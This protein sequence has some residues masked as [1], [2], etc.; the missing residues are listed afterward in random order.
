MPSFHQLQCMR[1]FVA[2]AEAGSFARAAHALQIGAASV[3]EHVANLER[4]LGAALFHRTTRSLHLTHEGTR[5]L[6]LCH[7]ILPR[8]DE[9]D[10]ELARPGGD[11]AL[12]GLLRIEMSDG[13]D[14][15]LLDAVH[16]FQRLHPAVSIHLYRSQ[17]PFDLAEA[18][19]DI[20]IRAVPPQGR[21]PART[22]GHSRTIF[23]AAPAYL[24]RMGVPQHPQDLLAHRCIGY[25]DPA[26]GRLWEWYFAEG[27]RRSFALDVPC[28]L[29]FS[30]GALRRR[31]AM[32][33]QGIINDIAHFVAE[34]VQQGMLVPIL[35]DWSMP[36][37]LCHIAVHRERHASPRITAFLAHL[38]MWLSTSTI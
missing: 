1:S 15:F 33:G 36:H 31:A 25:V 9:M 3:S 8:I 19:A 21:M 29:A 5:Y 20:A 11:A 38:D 28:P 32:A 34:P 35:S 18:H 17:R 24:D 4:H 16:E 13:I 26:S 23:L 27:D 30:E 12:S 6:A 7:D 2:V 37:P 14:A 22:L 10:A